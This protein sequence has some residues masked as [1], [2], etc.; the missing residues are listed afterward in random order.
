MCKGLP[1][2][3]SVLTGLVLGHRADAVVGAAVTF[4]ALSPKEEQL[5]AKGASVLPV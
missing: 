4:F 5:P 3:F 1:H 2:P